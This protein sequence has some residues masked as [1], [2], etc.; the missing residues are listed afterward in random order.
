MQKVDVVNPW[1]KWRKRGGS[2]AKPLRGQR[3]TRLTSETPL[4][5]LLTSPASGVRY[6]NHLGRMLQRIVDRLEI[7]QIATGHLM[8]VIS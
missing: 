1:M 2:S 3:Q 7:L 6:I 4:G 8:N 5:L